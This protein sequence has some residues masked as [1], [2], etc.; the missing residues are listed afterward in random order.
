M[1]IGAYQ[2]SKHMY[3]V[4]FVINGHAGRYTFLTQARADA[5]VATII[6]KGGN[7]AIAD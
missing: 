3:Q 4:R 1:H 5:F 6:A 7:A 2:M